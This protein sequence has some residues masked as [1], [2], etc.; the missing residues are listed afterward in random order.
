MMRE[1]Q[2]LEVQGRNCRSWVQDFSFLG[3]RGSVQH[4]PLLG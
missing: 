1:L 3:P 4:F 2:Q